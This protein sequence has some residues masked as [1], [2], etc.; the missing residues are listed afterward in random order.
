MINIRLSVSGFS[1]YPAQQQAGYQCTKVL[2][3]R[4]Q[5]GVNLRRRAFA[6]DKVMPQNSRSTPAQKKV[7]STR[8]AGQ[9][10]SLTGRSGCLTTP[11]PSFL[12]PVL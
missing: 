12:S 4:T 2:R 11:P 8:T 5:E 7:T 3:V 1:R 6:R 10:L 9:Y